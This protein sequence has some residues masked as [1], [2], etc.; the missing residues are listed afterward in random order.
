MAVPCF[1]RDHFEFEKFV[2]EKMNLPSDCIMSAEWCFCG[3]G[4]PLLY[5]FLYLKDGKDVGETLS[6]EQIFSM[7]GSDAV[8]KKTFERFLEM[9]GALLMCNCSSLLPDQGVVLCGNIINAVL[10][11]F[12]DDIADREKS[13]FLKGFLSNSC[14]NSYLETI[15]IYFTKE[16]DLSIKGCLVDYL[17]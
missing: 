6:G 2:K 9:L 16:V 5:E 3:R 15:P 12:K 11:K 4:I 10:P 8:S 14:V 7:I 13:H 1:D 17:Y